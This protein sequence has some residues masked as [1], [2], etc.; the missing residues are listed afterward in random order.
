MSIVEC[1]VVVVVVVVVGFAHVVGFANA[2]DA[3]MV[4]LKV[5]EDAAIKLQHWMCLGY[6]DRPRVSCLYVAWRGSLWNVC[7]RRLLVIEVAPW[8]LIY[9]L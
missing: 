1:I 4:A 6:L 8:R 7:L 3:A 2:R 5:T 9:E